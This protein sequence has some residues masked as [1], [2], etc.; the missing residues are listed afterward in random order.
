MYPIAFQDYL[1]DAENTASRR[2]SIKHSAQ[3]L[4]NIFIEEG[5]TVILRME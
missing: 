1:I 4:I 2:F 5:H 3:K